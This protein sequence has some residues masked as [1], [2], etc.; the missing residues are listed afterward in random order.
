MRMKKLWLLFA[1]LWS[2]SS[3]AQE[4]ETGQ[5]QFQV[6]VDNG[7]FE[8]VIDDTMYI[9]LYKADLAVGQHKAK[10]WSPGYD[11]KEVTFYIQ[12]DQVTRKY[13]PMKISNDRK[14][15]EADYKDYRMK[16]HKSFTVPGAISLT[17]A[18][19]TGALALNG[20]EL[21][22]SILSDIDLYHKSPNYYDAN[23]YK[24]RIL[25]RRQTYKVIRVM[26]YS[27]LGLTIASVATTIFTYTWFKKRYK[28][29]QLMAPSPFKDRFSLNINPVGF[30][31][32]YNLN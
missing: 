21:R 2:L 28:E 5:V 13:V 10:I 22:K 1:I 7:Y 24:Q 12:K 9:K 16:F 17:L 30:Q 11:T 15:Y 3:M 29:P 20:Y 8:I 27:T 23:F 19:S 6:D 18:L 25:D 31:M 26:Y 32:T 4:L 14:Q